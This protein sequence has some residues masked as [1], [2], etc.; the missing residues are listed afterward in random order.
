MERKNELHLSRGQ[1]LVRN[2]ILKH[3]Q[4]CTA[5]CTTVVCHAYN[6]NCIPNTD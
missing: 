1:K 6:V 3:V 2:N 4:L 5:H